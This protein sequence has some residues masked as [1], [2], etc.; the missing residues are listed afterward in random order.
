METYKVKNRNG[1]YFVS[2]DD[3]NPIFSHE[4]ILGKKFS[5][6]G[7]MNLIQ[8]LTDENIC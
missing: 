1:E 2:W 6:T 7:A 5:K 8:L 3:K 4:P